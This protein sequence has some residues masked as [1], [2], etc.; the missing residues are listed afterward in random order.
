MALAHKSD[1]GVPTDASNQGAISDNFL[2]KKRGNW[3][4]IQNRGSLGVKLHKIWANLTNSYVKFS[5]LQIF[6]NV[7]ILHS[8]NFDQKAKIGGHRV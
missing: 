7:M 1:G 8:G 3:G 5:D 6:P 4:Q 2:T